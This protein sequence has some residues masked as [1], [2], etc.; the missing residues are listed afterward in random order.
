MCLKIFEDLLSDAQLLSSRGLA[1]EF[2]QLVQRYL[3][4]CDRLCRGGWLLQLLTN[5]RRLSLK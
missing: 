1:R 2:Y 4:W 3:L 5:Q